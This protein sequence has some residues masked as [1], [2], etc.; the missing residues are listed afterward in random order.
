MRINK[1]KDFIKRL[2]HFVVFLFAVVEI[3][4]ATVPH[5]RI[6]FPETRPL[7]FAKILS[8]GLR[9]G[10]I[11]RFVVHECC[12]VFLK[13]PVPQSAADLDSPRFHER[14]KLPFPGGNTIIAFPDYRETMS[15]Q[16]GN[17]STA[18]PSRNDPKQIN[19][20]VQFIHYVFV[21]NYWRYYKNR[22]IRRFRGE[23]SACNRRGRQQ[24]DR[25]T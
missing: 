15:S 3:V 7:L 4:V 21:G 13:T 8:D 2:K 10:A 20:L 1:V 17:K 22:S 9:Q 16:G 19:P 14:K 11:S 12:R 5:C 6:Q 23:Q 24:R 18:Y 25:S